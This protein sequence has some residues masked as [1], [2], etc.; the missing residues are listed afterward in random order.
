MGLYNG[1]CFRERCTGHIL[2]LRKGKSLLVFTVELV[3][4]QVLGIT[5]KEKYTFY[6]LKEHKYTLLFH[7][8][9]STL[10]PVCPTRMRRREKE[11][12]KQ[13]KKL[14]N[15]HMPSCVQN[16]K[17][18]KFSELFLYNFSN[19]PFVLRFYSHRK[20]HRIPACV[21]LMNPFSL[22]LIVGLVILNMGKT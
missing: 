7:I 11:T 12:H 10:P 2:L 20:Q 15:M 19:I 17:H 14:E 21:T 8:W 18:N 13:K 1:P 4:K 6:F 9:Y 5:Q 16:I 3:M 22:F